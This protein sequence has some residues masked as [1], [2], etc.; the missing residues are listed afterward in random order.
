MPAPTEMPQYLYKIVPE[1]PPSPLPA[2]YPLS[3]LD[4]NDGFIHLSTADQVSPAPCTG[5]PFTRS[6]AVIRLPRM[7]PPSAPRFLSLPL[8]LLTP[9]RPFPPPPPPPAAPPSRPTARPENAANA[10]PGPR[11]R[12]PLL[13]RRREPL[14]PQAPLRRS[15]GADPVGR[16]PLGAGCFPHLYGRN[17]GA[18]D[19]EDARG[20]A[21]GEGQAW[22]EVLGGTRGSPEI[23]AAAAAAAP[24]TLGTARAFPSPGICRAR[25]G[26]KK[27]RGARPDTPCLDRELGYHLYGNSYVVWGKGGTGAQDE[28]TS[29]VK[30]NVQLLAIQCF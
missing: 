15:G 27:Q 29:T 18:A 26:G 28:R 9:A 14:A 22:G 3:D 13:L 23:A 8:S 10:T 19:I 24:C 5:C 7:H 11:D 2:E 30:A 4:R 1:A 25:A 20:F 12:G 21:K 17:F 16:P 6:C